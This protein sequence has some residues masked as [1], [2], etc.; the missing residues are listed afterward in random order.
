MGASL[1]LQSAGLNFILIP[2]AKKLIFELIGTQKRFSAMDTNERAYAL[3]LLAILKHEQT[4]IPARD[5]WC[6]ALAP[7]ANSSGEQMR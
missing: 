7:L 3:A 5:F 2:R 6:P 1:K 4:S